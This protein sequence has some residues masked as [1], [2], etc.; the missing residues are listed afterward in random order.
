MP[1]AAM[2]KHN[3]SK[4]REDQIRRAGQV[5]PMK[6]KAVAEGVGGASDS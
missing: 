4:A 5:A 6:T 1:K 2:D 3:L